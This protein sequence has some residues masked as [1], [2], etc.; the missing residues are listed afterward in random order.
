MLVPDV[1]VKS[2]VQK[3]FVLFTERSQGSLHGA[4]MYDTG[5]CRGESKRAKRKRKRENIW[6]QVIQ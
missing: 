3:P 2:A 5:L 6:K 4:L 1:P